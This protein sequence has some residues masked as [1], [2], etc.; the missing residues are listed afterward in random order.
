MSEID[1]NSEYKFHYLF[2]YFIYIINN[3]IGELSKII[4]ENKSLLEGVKKGIEPHNFENN[5]FRHIWGFK[6]FNGETINH[7]TKVS[8]IYN[9]SDEDIKKIQIIIK[10]VNDDEGVIIEQENSNAA[11][12]DAGII[13][14]IN[15]NQWKLYLIQ[16]TKIKSADERLTITFLNDI[17][18]FIKE[19][20][21]KKCKINIIKNYF[22]YIFDE[23]S[24]DKN[25]IEYCKKEKLD[26]LFYNS[27]ERKL[28][29]ENIYLK[30]Y[31]MKQKLFESNKNNFSYTKDFEIK[32]YYP[33]INISFEDTKEFLRRK[34]KIIKNKEYLTK[35]GL[36]ERLNNK[37]KYFSS[38]NNNFK[39]EKEIDYNDREEE[40]NNFLVDTE[41]KNKN[42]VGIK[43]SVPNQKDCKKKLNDL[44]LGDNV[45][46]NFFEILKK[47]KN[48]YLFLNIEEI[49]L[50]IPSIFIPEYLNYIIIKTEDKLYYQDYENKISVDLSNK[51]KEDFIVIYNENWKYIA[52]TL[53]NKNLAGEIE[54][55][56]VK[57]P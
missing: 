6:K 50:F 42:L 19:F 51:N 2:N 1:D 54:I 35:E 12:F 29:K 5:V 30:E 27:S 10:E 28:N 34:R 24:K 31:K 40:I 26:Y 8:S 13:V 11:F 48:H 15:E 7:K 39:R 47:D 33:K 4:N 36:I 25:T 18:G 23:E 22:C 17:F 55:F 45:I 20:L 32:K 44:G 3:L 52:I 46:N 49:D 38:I 16:T 57:K 56:Q 14:K 41:F 43:I 9:L 21:L 53:I 37:Q